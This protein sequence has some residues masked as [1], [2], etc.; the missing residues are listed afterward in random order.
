VEACTVTALDAITAFAVPKPQLLLAETVGF[1]G[2]GCSSGCPAER[3]TQ[4]TLDWQ[5]LFRQSFQP[6]TPAKL[7]SRFIDVNAILRVKT[8]ISVHGIVEK[9]DCWSPSRFPFVRHRAA[10]LRN[11]TQAPRENRHE[12]A[13]QR[14]LSDSQINVVLWA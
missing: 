9:V 12:T 6:S 10:P 2:S 11:S 13:S 4:P 14:I 8:K 5:G 3:I 1:F 7:N